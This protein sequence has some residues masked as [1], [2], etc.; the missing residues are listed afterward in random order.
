GEGAYGEVYRGRHRASGAS[1]AVKKLKI[2]ADGADEDAEMARYA[3]LTAERELALLRAM[4]DHANVVRFTDSW[5][6][7]LVAGS[8]AVVA[9]VLCF[10]L[11]AMTALHALEDRGPGAF[12]RGLCLAL[13]RDLCAALAHIHALRIVHRDIKPE[14]VLLSGAPGGQRCEL[15]LCDFGAARQLEGDLGP[16]GVGLAP[17]AA[18]GE[19]THYIGSRW[20]RAPEMM[21]SSTTYGLRVDVWGAACITA[22]LAT[23]EPLFPGDEE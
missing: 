18:A 10:E 12:G 11:L 15:K 16:D 8:I 6:E 23:G 22:E 13:T 20:Y 19:L 1:V 3:V 5:Q 2:V 14:N 21:A 17:Q 4:G 9:P 7:D